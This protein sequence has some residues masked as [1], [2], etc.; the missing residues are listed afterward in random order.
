MGIKS[1]IGDMGN[2]GLTRH[3][4]VRQRTTKQ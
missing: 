3:L 1:D 2:P 4:T